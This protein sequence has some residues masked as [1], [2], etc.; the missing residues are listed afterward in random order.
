M[1]VSTKKGLMGRYIVSDPNICPGQP[2][3]R[4]T[5]VLVADVLEQVAHGMAWDAIVAEWRGSVSRA[6]I[7]EAVQLAR[8]AFAGH[9]TTFPRL[10]PQ[11]ENHFPPAPPPKAQEELH[12][13][14]GLVARGWATD[15]V[16]REP[17]GR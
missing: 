2:T 10:Q 7:A 8:E 9:A 15:E 1:N 11:R 5:R 14:F 6:A 12:S 4:G 13:V 3:F 16:A 17:G